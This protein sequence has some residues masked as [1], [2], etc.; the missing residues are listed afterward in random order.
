MHSFMVTQIRFYGYILECLKI[1]YTLKMIN[2]M[3]IMTMIRW[4]CFSQKKSDKPISIA[5][6]M[7]R[8]RNFQ[9]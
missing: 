8:I 6:A 4:N 9:E 2:L 1:G 5:I 7:T 3:G